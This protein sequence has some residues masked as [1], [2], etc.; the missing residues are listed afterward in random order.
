MYSA[1]T[2]PSFSTRSA[3]RRA[4]LVL[5]FLLTCAALSFA[6]GA[7]AVRLLTPTPILQTPPR[8]VVSFTVRVENTGAASRSLVVR[9]VPPPGWRSLATD[10][11]LSL[12]PGMSEVFLLSLLVP[13][14]TAGSDYA[15]GVQVRDSGDE[16]VTADLTL[17]VRVPEVLALGITLAEAPEYAIA[18]TEYEV[19]FLVTNTGNTRATYDL[20]VQSASGF[21]FS[22][23]GTLL[24]HELTAGGR[25]TVRIRVQSDQKVRSAVGHRV[26]VVARLTGP[27]TVP[28]GQP[29]EWL[30]AAVVEVIPLS[31]GGAS[32]PHTIPAG[33]D[34]SA[35]LVLDR[36]FSAS[37]TETFTA[38][39]SLDDAGLHGVELV[40]RK[41]AATGA[42]LLGNPQDRYSIAYRGPVGEAQLGDHIYSLSPLLG[43]FR[44]GRGAELGGIVGPVRIWGLYFKD[45]WDY[46]GRED[47]GAFAELSLPANGGDGAA[48]HAGLAVTSPMTGRLS[49]DLLQIFHP[50]PG[51]T[52]E[53]DGALQRLANGTVIPAVLGVVQGE[54]GIVS[55]NARYLRAW[56]GFLGAYSDAQSIEA[57]GSLSLLGSDLE[58]SAGVSLTDGN[59]AMDPAQ[60]GAERSRRVHLGVRAIL[61]GGDTELTANWENGRRSDRLPLARYNTWQNILSASWAQKLGSYGLSVNARLD[62]VFDTISG[63]VAIAQDHSVRLEYESAAGLLYRLSLHYSGDLGTNSPARHATG[64]EVAVQREWTHTT[65]DGAAR[66]TYTI[67]GGRLAEMAVQVEG[68]LSHTFVWGHKLTAGAKLGAAETAGLWRPTAGLEASYG[69]P[70][71]IPV[72]WKSGRVIVRGRVYH[73][74]TNLPVAGVTVR[75]TG[76]ATVTGKNGSFV[77]YLPSPGTHYLLLDT[78][79]AGAGLVATQPV[80]V[81]ISTVAG[82]TTTVDIALT[83]GA[84][85]AGSV[86]AWSFP[87]ERDV[88]ERTGVAGSTSPIRTRRQGLGNVLMEI[89]GPLETKRRLT[90]PGGDFSFEGLVPGSYTLTL[91][92]GSV[93][94]SYV[95]EQPSTTVTLAPGDRQTVE[96][97]LV[98]QRRQIRMLTE[99]IPLVIDAPALTP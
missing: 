43:V 46:P 4:T 59:L 82:S 42:V 58:V 7:L 27:S 62:D 95:L 30:A 35:G 80:P 40:V 65:V 61:A 48:Y 83:T 66:N 97:R 74:G 12:A 2:S 3:A 78:R 88:L 34:S 23:D 32:L 17:T 37:L 64:W 36:D 44:L 55:Y 71:N 33:I 26:Q 49:L 21:A 92:E 1:P 81:E 47:L 54:Q 90:G 41:R 84:T 52:L 6:D 9:A 53:L 14:G 79:V 16:T 39:G 99:D 93:P 94:S 18:G 75:T 19:T 20:E 72:P 57:G 24:G 11:E 29:A 98:Q 31:V 51:L 76:L 28:E 86:A 56:P 8:Q 87:D 69:V 60:T 63:A 67:E 25:E 50:L 38:K 96:I 10:A 73:E 45:V 22:V 91:F 89:A 15:V 13:Q 5:L 68:K 85:L 77:F 70:M